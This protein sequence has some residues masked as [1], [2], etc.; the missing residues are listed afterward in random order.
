M[1]DHTHF[2][3]RDGKEAGHYEHDTTPETIKYVG[4][5]TMATKIYKLNDS[6]KSYWMIDH[7]N[8]SIKI[9][10]LANIKALIKK[11]TSLIQI[12]NSNISWI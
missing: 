5:Y 1:C 2:F 7:I 11:L 3:K 9:D 12:T 10:L 8:N 6:Y 4:Y